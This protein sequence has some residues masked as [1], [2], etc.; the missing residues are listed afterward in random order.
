MNFQNILT[1]ACE[2]SASDVILSTG[3][4]PCLKV[5]G[6][7]IFLENESPSTKNGLEEVAGKIMNENQKKAF[8]ANKEI[9]FAIE[10]PN[11]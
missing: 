4:V 7:I 11:F 8:L 6:D 2:K 1:L 9:D 3:S 10:I 5:H